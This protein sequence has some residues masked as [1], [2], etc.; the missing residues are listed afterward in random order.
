MYYHQIHVSFR[1]DPKK[2]K[3]IRKSCETDVFGTCLWQFH[4]IYKA[5]IIAGEK[6]GETR[7]DEHQIYVKSEKIKW[8]I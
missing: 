3:Y 4:E 5:G 6:A 7:K 2:W 1:Q 8:E